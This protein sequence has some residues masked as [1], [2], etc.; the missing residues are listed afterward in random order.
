[1]LYNNIN[2]SININMSIS[3]RQHCNSNSWKREKNASCLSLGALAVTIQRCYCFTMLAYISFLSFRYNMAVISSCFSHHIKKIYTQPELDSFFFLLS[4]V[5]SLYA[6]DVVT[7][8]CVFAYF[9]YFARWLFLGKMHWFKN[10]WL[11]DIDKHSTHTHTHEAWQQWQRQQHCNSKDFSSYFSSYIF[12]FRSC[13]CCSLR[14]PDFKVL[15]QQKK[16]IVSTHTHT[17]YVYME[18]KK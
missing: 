14:F 7:I 12:F 17:L 2:I 16:N 13:C 9:A 6:F 18:E 4:L 15:L 1:M 8:S 3:N 5:V 11:K 10:E